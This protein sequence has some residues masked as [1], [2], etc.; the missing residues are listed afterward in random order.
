MKYLLA[1]V[2]MYFLSSASLKCENY[3]ETEWY[4]IALDSI[5]G[6]TIDSIEN[7]KYDLFPIKEGFR[8]A[9]IFYLTADGE[10]KV[11]F[12]L[13]D[14]K[15]NIYDSSI[16]INILDLNKLAERVQYHKALE[17]GEYE[18]GSKKPTILYAKNS[19]YFPIT[20]FKKIKIPLSPRSKTNSREKLMSIQYVLCTSMNFYD[21]KELNTLNQSYSENYLSIGGL[22]NIPVSEKPDLFFRIGL[23]SGTTNDYIRTFNLMFLHKFFISNSNIS[24]ILGFGYGNTH[25]YSIGSYIIEANKHY[26]IL[27]FGLNLIKDWIDIICYIPIAEELITYYNGKRYKINL[28]GM[29]INFCII[30]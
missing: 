6:G 18:M 20:D 7:V 1:F 28:V 26:P 21:I 13:K 8:K 29:E 11:V 22:I 12:R 23:K 4:K 17:S 24:A 27:S 3:G 16:I 30:L 19:G 25:F 5:V 14:S 9:E 15:M 2:V 10:Y